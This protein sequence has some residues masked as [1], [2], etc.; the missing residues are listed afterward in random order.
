ML[1]TVP[2]LAA[3]SFTIFALALLAEIGWHLNI[4]PVLFRLAL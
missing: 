1:L 3:N 4:L 2:C